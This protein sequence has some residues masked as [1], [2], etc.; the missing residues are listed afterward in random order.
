MKESEYQTKVIKKIKKIFNLAD[1]DVLKND[2]AY[3]SGIPDWVIFCG[4]KYA[5]LEIKI[6]ETANIQPGQPYYINHFNNQSFARFIYPENEKEVLKD[7]E[8]YFAK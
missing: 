7:L 5:M 4:Q 2:S 8:E 1:E 6:S 3:I